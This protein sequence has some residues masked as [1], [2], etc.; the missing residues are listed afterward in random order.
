[1]HTSAIIN[2]IKQSIEILM[3]MKIDEPSKKR[4]MPKMADEIRSARE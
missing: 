3:N 1:M 4:K 2:Y